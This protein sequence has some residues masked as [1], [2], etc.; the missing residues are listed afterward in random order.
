[1]SNISVTQASSTGSCTQSPTGTRIGGAPGAGFQFRTGPGGGFATRSGNGSPPKNPG[2]AIRNRLG[3][4][5]IASGKVT[6]VNGSTLSVSGVSLSPGSFRRPTSKE[7]K[8]SKKP[9]PPKPENLKLT[10]SSSTTVSAT[11]SATSS[12]LAV[13]D[14]V[15]AFG[16]AASNGSVTAD[17][18]RITSTNSNSCMGGFTKFGGGGGGGPT[19]F[20]GPGG[21]DQGF[22]Q[23][24]AGGGGA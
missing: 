2:A 20:G 8:D 24:P 11:Q 23:V 3:N 14:C 22:A 1:V 16:P 6:A 19:I 12:D 5:T 18:V 13:G 21:G 10:T 9:T 7:S 17:N 4:F 15:I